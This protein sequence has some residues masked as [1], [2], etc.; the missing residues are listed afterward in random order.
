[1][2]KLILVMS[3]TLIIAS[4]A[5]AEKDYGTA[6]CGWGSQVMGK[7]GSQILAATT[8][9][10][11][12]T[13]VF[14]ITSGT[15]NCTDDGTVKTAKLMPVFIESNRVSLA[16][17]IA[18]GNGETIASLSEILG[19]GNSALLG[20]ELQKNYQAIFPNEAVSNDKVAGSIMEVIKTNGKLNGSCS[21][22]S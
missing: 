12:Y 18:R 13:Q 21:V 8:N 7:G 3:A 11:S 1:M 19:C 10:T 16:N 9:D 2:R 6:G 5:F 15:S 17:D 4:P 22:Q 20:A 14:G